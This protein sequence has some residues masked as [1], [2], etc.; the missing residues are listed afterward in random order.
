MQ[1]LSIEPMSTTTETSARTD[2]Y[3]VSNVDEVASPA[4]LI[5]PDRVEENIRADGPDR[6]R[7]RS[8]STA[9]EDKQAA[10]SHPDADRLRAS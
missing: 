5:Y 9:H 1:T 10:R 2:W 3:T 8:S 6:G 4:L 7:R